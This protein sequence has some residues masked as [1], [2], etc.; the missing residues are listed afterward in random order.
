M[1]EQSIEVVRGDVEVTPTFS[2]AIPTAATEGARIGVTRFRIVRRDK[3]LAERVSEAYKDGLET[4][5]K[6]LLDRA[7]GQFGRRLSGKG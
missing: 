4:E 7:A 3:S 6:E 2:D 1:T 5:E